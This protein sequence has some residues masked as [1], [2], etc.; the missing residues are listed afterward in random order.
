MNIKNLT[1]KVPDD[2]SELFD[3]VLLRISQIDGH[4]VIAVHQGDQPVH[5]IVH[6]LEWSCLFT[7]TVD[8]KLKFFFRFDK[9]WA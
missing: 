1:N 5:Q 2:L 7:V 6:V 8:L 4:R 3:G 9:T